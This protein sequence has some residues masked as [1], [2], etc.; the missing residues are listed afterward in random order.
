MSAPTAGFDV[1]AYMRAPIQLRPTDGDV[2]AMNALPAPALSALG[3]LWQIE[4]TALVR[5][6]DVLVTPTHAETRVS[7]FL[8]TWAYEQHWLAA[9]LQRLLDTS[10][11]PF[12]ELVD[13]KLGQMRRS[14]DDRAHP[15]VA[16]IATNLMGAEITG[17]HMVTAWLDT[18]V[19]T[20][21]YRR[22]GEI[23]PGLKEL[24]EAITQM[25]NRHLDFYAEEANTRLARSATA[26]R[27][28]RS[29]VT[30]WR[31]PGT[32]YAGPA[33][34]R[35]HIFPLFTDPASRAAL[36]KINSTAAAFP[37]LTR[38]RPVLP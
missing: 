36:E 10:G 20:L 17:A 8:T 14:W 9:T 28:A 19:L 25:K 16:A 24:T 23:E 31:F 6:R 11:R 13:T 12:P 27:I 3:Y 30:R 5:M 18:A 29:A 26:R 37:G 33:P 22:L 7:A 1:R 34:A 2:M 15:A 35:A 38:A 4:R 21:T 32:H